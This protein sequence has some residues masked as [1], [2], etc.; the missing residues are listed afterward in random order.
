MNSNLGYCFVCF[1]RTLRDRSALLHSR[2]PRHEFRKEFLAQSHLNT[3]EKRTFDSQFPLDL[4][5]T[6]CSR[7]KRVQSSFEYRFTSASSLFN[8]RTLSLLFF[9]DFFIVILQHDINNCL[10]CNCS[11]IDDNILF[12]RWWREKK[13][14][15]WPQTLAAYLFFRVLLNVIRLDVSGIGGMRWRFFIRKK[16]YFEFFI[17]SIF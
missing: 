16:K 8:C 6:A 5:I 14:S 10:L 4:M 15:P 9:A 7:C 1:V 17:L 13:F 11:R 3:H 2:P 12:V